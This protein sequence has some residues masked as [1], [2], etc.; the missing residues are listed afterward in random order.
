MPSIRVYTLRDQ[1]KITPGD[2]FSMDP[3]LSSSKHRAVAIDKKT[4]VAVAAFL[5]ANG[6]A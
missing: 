3:Q 5:K 1:G 2:V 4:P 6:P